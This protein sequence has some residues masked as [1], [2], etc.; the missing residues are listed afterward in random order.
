MFCVKLYFL[1]IMLPYKL[2]FFQVGWVLCNNSLLWWVEAYKQYWMVLH[3][4][5]TNSWLFF[6]LGFL[7][8]RLVIMYN[9]AQEILEH[10]ILIPWCKQEKQETL[11][12]W[13]WS[14]Q[15]FLIASVYKQAFK[16]NSENKWGGCSKMLHLYRLGG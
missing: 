6:S 8:Y 14:F 5:Q 9:P 7:N 12:S 10:L 4:F 3:T 1:K 16:N 11:G 2:T 13:K 15:F